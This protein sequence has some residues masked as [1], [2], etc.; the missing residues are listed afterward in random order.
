LT[1]HLRRYVST[2]ASTKTVRTDES[3]FEGALRAL[4]ASAHRTC[5]DPSVVKAS[6][7]ASGCVDASPG[8][9]N[10][11]T[12]MGGMRPA[13]VIDVDMED[14]E[15][16]EM[17]EREL[18]QPL[19]L[20]LAEYKRHPLYVLLRD[21]RSTQ[22]IYPPST[23]P[24]GICKGQR[25]YPRSCVREMRSQQA[26][27][28]R[29]FDL[30]PGSQPVKMGAKPVALGG[31]A[32][33]ARAAAAAEGEVRVA[34]GAGASGEGTELFGE[35]QT[36]EHVPAMAINGIVP[37]ST[38]GHV[39]L[40]TERHLPYGTVHLRG[41]HVLKA[42]KQL[43]VDAAPAMVGFDVHDGRAVPKFDGV[44]V[45]TE[46]AEMLGEAAAMLTEQA[47]DVE[48]HKRHEEAL[49]SW[50]LLLRSLLLRRRIEKQYGTSE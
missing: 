26:W 40:W 15:E 9:S 6:P 14:A 2:I 3:W 34:D 25:V 21:L 27:F 11:G 43:G 23:K 41:A 37:R 30:R 5:T 47:E 28:R 39:E 7:S 24:L 19:P 38:H 45:C 44:V 4:D 1:M 12:R 20:T 32:A 22:M 46:H 18:S 29:G 33:A 13:E 49:A 10:N 42:A 48:A 16:R 50:R 35:W 36:I 31:K 8:S 17:R